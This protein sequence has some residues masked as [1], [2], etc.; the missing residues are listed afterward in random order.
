LVQNLAKAGITEYKESDLDAL[1]EKL[2]DSN[3]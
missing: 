2:S 1:I 3:G